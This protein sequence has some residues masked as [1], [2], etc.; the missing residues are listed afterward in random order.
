MWG[1]LSRR[2]T[3]PQKV[4][5]ARHGLLTAPSQLIQLPDIATLGAPQAS[6]FGVSSRAFARTQHATGSNL[7]SPRG[8]GSHF[9]GVSRMSLSTKILIVLTVLVFEA[10]STML[11]VEV[12]AGH[13]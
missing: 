6:A 7:G 4:K 2:C 11:T 1:L 8:A 10:A 13:L 9:A 5:N 12:L 3:A